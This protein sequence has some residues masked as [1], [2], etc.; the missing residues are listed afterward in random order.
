MES[1]PQGARGPQKLN[2]LTIILEVNAM[3]TVLTLFEHSNSPNG[4][5]S[6]ACAHAENDLK[7]SHTYILLPHMV[8][9]V[10]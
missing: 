1:S 7:I 2:I 5:L 4:K 3:T 9:Y 8:C 6:T 10:N